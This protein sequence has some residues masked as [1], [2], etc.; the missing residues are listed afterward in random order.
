MSTKKP[1][2]WFFV[3][4]TDTFGGEA[5]YSWVRRYKLLAVSL[6]GAQLKMTREEGNG[7]TKVLDS[8]DMQRW[9]SASSCTCM[10][11]EDYDT[12]KHGKLTCNEL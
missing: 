8:G 4:V 11:I 5:N 7:W 10:F 9:D 6:K 2:T 1:K 12:D 3:E